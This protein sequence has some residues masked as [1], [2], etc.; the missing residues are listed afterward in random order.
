MDNS[1]MYEDLINKKFGML[2]VLRRVNDIE[3]VS[4]RKYIAYECICECGRKKTTKAYSLIYGRCCSC[5]HHTSKPKEGSI[6]SNKTSKRLYSILSGMKS[7][8]FSKNNPNFNHYGG[9]GITIC[10]EW[11]DNFRSFEKWAIENGYR[12][13]L[14]IDRIDVN[15]NYE[16]D[17]C[18]WI[19]NKEQ[20]NNK[21]NT[22]HIDFC[23][24]DITLKELSNL[25]GIDRNTLY[26]RYSKGIKDEK[27][28]CRLQRKKKEVHRKERE[29]GMLVTVGD[30]TLSICQ[31]SK[32]TGISRSTLYNR[33]LAGKTGKDFIKKPRKKRSNKC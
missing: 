1:K 11:I 29:P 31:W 24:E 28:L 2:T 19:T 15:G 26:S 22:V 27:I 14:T 21:R 16:P 32:E 25:T 30:R 4:G 5:G 13:D 23:G 6:M 17:N 12:N 3:D 33:H 7:R 10:Q 9:R 8:C 18:R 20:Q